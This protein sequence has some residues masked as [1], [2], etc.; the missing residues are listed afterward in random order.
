M[1]GL[2][3]RLVGPSGTDLGLGYACPGLGRF[4]LP[5][6]GTYTVEV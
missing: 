3:W 4:V 5:D 6:A 1:N 2:Q